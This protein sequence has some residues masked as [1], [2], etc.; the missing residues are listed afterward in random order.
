MAE[1]HEVECPD[2]IGWDAGCG[3]IA[4][5]VVMKSPQLC[6]GRVERRLGC[7]SRWDPPLGFRISGLVVGIY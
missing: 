2:E 5:G 4:G 1:F 6:G 3:R 7:S